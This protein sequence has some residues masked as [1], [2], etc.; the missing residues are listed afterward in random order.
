MFAYEKQRT[1]NICCRASSKN[2]ESARQI[3]D[4]IEQGSERGL[5][6][7]MCGDY[8]WLPSLEPWPPRR[9]ARVVLDQ[10]GR[11]DYGTPGA[12]L[13][14]GTLSCLLKYTGGHTT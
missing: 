4:L 8:A 13:C 10:C 1:F 11:V 2:G 7:C 9:V 12:M 14:G 3:P 5:I 6:V